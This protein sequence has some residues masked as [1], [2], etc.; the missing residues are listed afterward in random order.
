MG[1]AL[2]QN[3]R[4]EVN[5]LNMG[6]QNAAEEIDKSTPKLLTVNFL[7]PYHYFNFHL[8]GTVKLAQVKQ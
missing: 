2:P 1:H 7:N 5:R 8:E 3:S 6:L 4:A